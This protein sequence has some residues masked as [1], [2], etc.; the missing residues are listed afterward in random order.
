MFLKQKSVAVNMMLRTQ[1][2]ASYTHPTPQQIDDIEIGR[3]VLLGNASEAYVHI[4]AAT[5][6]EILPGLL[7]HKAFGSTMRDHS[8][9]TI[10]PQT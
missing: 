9:Q 10:D 7:H 4:L 3:A 1:L 2:F 5:V 8:R 6:V